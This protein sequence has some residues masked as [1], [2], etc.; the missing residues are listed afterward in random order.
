MN[1]NNGSQKNIK[2]ISGEEYFGVDN[3]SKNVYIGT[4][5]QPKENN[6]YNKISTDDKYIKNSLNP[7]TQTSTRPKVPGSK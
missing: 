2:K 5:I 6:S 3:N 7:N 1:I 4:A